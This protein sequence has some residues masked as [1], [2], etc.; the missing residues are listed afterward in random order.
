MIR[1]AITVE[2]FEA[3]ARTLTLGSVGYE[4]EASEQGQRLI[5][6]EDAMADQLGAMRGPGRLATLSYV[7][8]GRRRLPLDAGETKLPLGAG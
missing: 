5:R 2:A 1:I 4:A 7:S 8:R 3:I 6:L